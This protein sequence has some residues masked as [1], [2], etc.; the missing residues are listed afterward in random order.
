MI[1]ASL[2]TCQAMDIKRKNPYLMDI[3]NYEKPKKE[4][5]LTEEQ[6]IAKI[7]DTQY[8][9]TDKTTICIM[10]LV[11]GFEIIGKA[12]V[13]DDRMN[14]PKIGQKVARDRA[15]QQIWLVEGY[16]VQQEF[17]EEV[18]SQGGFPTKININ[19]ITN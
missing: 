19:K 13:I 15:I 14:D 16:L 18:I 7:V 3:E 10:K 8:V 1:L 4:Y 9:H 5:R 6:I 2:V 11:N 12:G 17:Y